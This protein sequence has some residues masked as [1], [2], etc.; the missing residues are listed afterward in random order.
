MDLVEVLK[1]TNKS[2][3]ILGHDTVDCDSA[4]SI[5][6][7]SK[8][9][10]HLKVPNRAVILDKTISELDLELLKGEGYDLNKYKGSLKKNEAVFLVDHYKTSHSTSVVGC[11]DHHPTSEKVSYSFYQNKSS[12]STSKLIFDL[13]VKY[14]YPVTIKEIKLIILS[15]MVDTCSLKSTKCPKEHATWVKDTCKKYKIDYNKY[16]KI[17]LCLSNLNKPLSIVTTEGLKKYCYS[18][19]NVNSSYIQV[20]SDVDVAKYTEHLKTKIKDGLSLWVFLV[21]NL[22]SDKTTEYRITKAG[23]EVIPY[24]KVTSRGTDVMPVIEKNIKKIVK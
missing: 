6:L 4:V 1:G 15:M 21:H 5:L 14:N 3:A 18:G 22:E 23:I 20:D 13:M 9:L 2:I 17:G 16:Y 11:I 7:L 19:I 10:T 12:A 8:L 24:N